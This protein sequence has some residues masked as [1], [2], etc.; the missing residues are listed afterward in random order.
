[1]SPIDQELVDLY[2]AE[3]PGLSRVIIAAFV[4]RGEEP[5]SG[6]R[7]TERGLSGAESIIVEEY[8]RKNDPFGS[9]AEVAKL[10]EE[11]SE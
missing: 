2:A 11:G 9:Q 4:E 1:M 3:N 7:V 10:K 6:L 5:P 8:K